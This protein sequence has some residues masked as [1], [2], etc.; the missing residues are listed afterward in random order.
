MT[1]LIALCLSL[2][3]AGQSSFTWYFGTQAGIR[4]T[5]GGATLPAAGSYM[6][7]GE[8]STVA[9][10]T[11]GVI[12]FYSDGIKVWNNSSATPVSSALLGNQSATQAALAIAL[13]GSDCHRFLVFTTT[14]V[15]STTHDLGVALVNVTGTSPAYAVSVSE[16]ALPVVENVF[17]GEKLA[18]TSDTSGGYWVVAHDYAEGSATATTFYKY[19]ITQA[20]FGAVTTT[21]QAQA[22]LATV[23]QTQAIGSNHHDAAPPNFNAQGQMKFS[24][25]GQKLGLVLAGS[26]T[27]DLFSFD[28]TTGLLTLIATTTVSPSNG[29]LYG[30]ELSPN[31]SKLYASEGFAS[32][33][34]TIRKIYQWDISG[35]TLVNPYT[36]A[37]GSNVYSNRYKYNALQLGPNDKIYCSEEMGIA[38]LSVI[39][40]PNSAG[41]ACGWSSMTEPIAGTNMLGLTT[42]MSNFG[43]SCLA[44]PGAITGPATACRGASGLVY[45]IAAVQGATGYNWSLPPGVVIQSGA[46]TPVITVSFTAT[47]VSGPI[48]VHAYNASCNSVGSPTF[49]VTVSDAPV[50]DL[51]P[52]QDICE[53]QSVT[54]NA[55]TCAGCSYLWSNLATGQPNIGTGPTYTTG[56][57]GIYAVSVVNA[58]NCADADTI[59]VSVRI[60]FPVSVS[61]AA[62]ANPVCAGTTVTF[63]ATP[64]NGGTMPSF[65]WKVNAINAPNA[66]NATYTYVPA[67]GDAMTCEVTSNATCTTGNPAVS[68]PVT[69]TVNVLLPVSVTIAA[70][71]NPVCA[72]TSVT[73]TSTTLNGGDMPSYQWKINAASVANATNATYSYVPADGDAVTCEVTSNATCTTGNPAVSNP[74]TMTVNVLLPVS[75]T[76]AASANP[77]CAGTSVTFT[78]TPLNGGTNPFYQWKVNGANAGGNSPSHT[79]I[80]ANGDSLTCV[81]MSNEPCALNNQAI[82]N[83]I[84]ISHLPAPAVTLTAC[85]DTITTLNAKPIRL[86]GGQPLNGTWSGPGV[87][88]GFFNPAAAGAGVHPLVYTNINTDGCVAS[89]TRNV[90]CV[91]S[92]AFTCGNI[93]TDIRD[94]RTYPTVQIGTQC[95]LAANLDYGMTIGD[96][97]PQTDNC[98]PEGYIR[99]STFGVQY[100][101]FYQWDELMD[102]DPAPGTKGLCMP[103]WHVPTAGEWVELASHFLGPG[104]SGKYLQDPALTG[105]EAAPSGILYHNILW[106]FTGS[107]TMFW[108][109]TSSGNARAT[110]RGFHIL[111]YSVSLYQALRDQALPV[112]CLLD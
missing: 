6:T 44:P 34:T 35:G 81:I 96:D 111:N 16:P 64:M 51:G 87:S 48:T 89:A 78:A 105:F 77:V 110:A 50:V 68:N 91:N 99:N 26:R 65:Q 102:Y 62:S 83:T 46:N 5:S 67:D 58:G 80:P 1:G 90:H 85:F 27:V 17:F 70:S 108:T 100:S 63:T 19:H 8:G 69:M 88:G 33:G 43:C 84:V 66:T 101:K 39:Q 107:A 7:A 23:Q 41:V 4:F 25:T 32:A 3:S 95:W 22:A 45:S 71:A 49:S 94:G 47:A 9:S 72:G 54:L 21:A 55:G 86:K 93:L 103:G 60:S 18:A 92:S 10:D 61:V 98:R 112:R 79:Y 42:V 28:L 73:F 13:P 97:H 12:L 20:V 59:L 11:A 36:V 30:C 109:S 14:G 106:S 82:S 53:G 74:V 38:F 52:D 57:A 40:N 104:V 56:T 76:I 29:N 24:K 37:S 75:V 2:A 31:G 15:E